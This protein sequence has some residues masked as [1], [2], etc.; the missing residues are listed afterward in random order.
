MAVAR[1][2]KW[3][4]RA[5]RDGLPSG[6]PQAYLVALI[7][8]ALASALRFCLDLMASDVLPFSSFFPAILAATLIGGSGPGILAVVLSTALR[9]VDFAGSGGHLVWPTA[10]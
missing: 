7:C 4:R 10:T 8:I 9:W 6:S 2:T 1:T 3:L 5:W